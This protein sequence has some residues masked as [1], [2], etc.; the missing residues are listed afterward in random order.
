MGNRK[1]VDWIVLCDDGVEVC[2]VTHTAAAAFIEAKERGFKPISP[3]EV[4]EI[5]S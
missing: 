1:L 5:P 2:I 4:T 3:N